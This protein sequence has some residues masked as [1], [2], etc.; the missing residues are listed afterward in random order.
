MY[1][2][3][4]TEDL[5]GQYTCRAYNAY[6]ESAESTVR[7][8]LAATEYV[9][10]EPLPIVRID[11]ISSQGLKRELACRTNGAKF[12][13]LF[14]NVPV[15]NFPNLQQKNE[16]LEI[17]IIGIQSFGKYT[18]RSF[19][20]AGQTSEV[21]IEL[22]AHRPI[23]VEV[24]PRSL[25]SLSG[26]DADFACLVTN[27]DQGSLQ[28]E[29]E[30]DGSSLPANA[31]QTENGL[32]RIRNLNKENSG[33]YKCIVTHPKS[34][35]TNSSSAS[36]EVTEN[37]QLE[38]L[39]V[40]IQ[41]SSD[42]K[43]IVGK[44]AELN[45]IVNGGRNN[46]I[47]W[48]KVNDKLDSSRFETV[49]STLIIKE[50]S[51]N[52]R[53]YFECK[54]EN[55]SENSVAYV[56]V[57]VEERIRPVVEAWPAGD[58][59][60]KKG[61]STYVQCRVVAGEP[62]PTVEWKRV[63]GRSFSSRVSIINAG[64][65]LSV[66]NAESS[67]F[68]SYECVAEN[69]AGQT[70][71]SI[72]LIEEK[73][74]EIES[75]QQEENK[76]E[77]INVTQQNYAPRIY[78]GQGNQANPREGD[79]FTLHCRSDR[80]DV[81]L[82]W[83]KDSTQL[84]SNDG[85]YT[86]TNIRKEDEG[87]YTCKAENSYG[88]TSE[89]VQVTV[90]RVNNVRIQIS[91]KEQV[92][93]LDGNTELSCNIENANNGEILYQWSKPGGRLPANHQVY[94]NVLRINKA[95]P[96]DAGRYVC[97]VSI[98]LSSYYDVAH[99]EVSENDPK[100]A[101]PVYIKVLEKPQVTASNPTGAFK[102]GTKLTIECY[103]KGL[104]LHVRP[105]WRK[106][107]GAS[108]T[109]RYTIDTQETSS[110]ITIPAVLPIDFGKYLCTAEGYTAEGNIAVGQSEISIVRELTNQ[111]KYINHGPKELPNQTNQ[112]LQP[113]EQ[114]NSDTELSE[115][116][117]KIKND[118]SNAVNEGQSLTLTCDVKGNPIPEIKWE[119]NNGELPADHRI[120]NNILR[121][122]LIFFIAQKII[123]IILIFL[124]FE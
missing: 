74:Q 77:I 22:H 75:D 33:I 5:S 85:D 51:N 34:G 35:I 26:D 95:Q 50:V 28:I 13:W 79:D 23:I 39:R 88:S 124:K 68:G 2:K 48:N 120:I 30:K 63:D 16:N 103:V 123:E 109:S 107:D 112:N 82:Q 119:K 31:K 42:V 49:G 20:L 45:C 72:S 114:E 15:S 27:Q 61:D 24:N 71:I 113:T 100:S 64:T 18:C 81:V 8:R 46:K 70:S 59:K 32:L 122:V 115:P 44:P 108:R 80:N 116:V 3:R 69:L 7:V 1:V 62:S 37:I 111:F 105:T 9:D 57:D 90:E 19:N 14:N 99:L 4:F 43:F 102:F 93:S 73:E 92:V 47:Q 101:F 41:P 78:L 76:P 52:D 121:C 97:T 58:Q 6:G 12:I 117:V 25:N 98:G 83:L 66:Q 104:T 118:G 65:V 17:N 91:P 89:S 10:E 38:P 53:G 11:E 40:E 110:T 96:E 84:V 55:E 60:I 54:V 56:L 36:L 86:I 29:W 87:T 106:I 94:S 21:S 67:D